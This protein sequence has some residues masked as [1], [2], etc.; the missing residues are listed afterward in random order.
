MD[1]DPLFS[2]LLFALGNVHS[3]NLSFSPFSLR[4]MLND[5][6]S[7]GISVNYPPPT[8]RLEVGASS[9]LCV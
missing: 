2:E 6:V 1:H 5:N 7:S 4:I 9:D 3:F 8:L